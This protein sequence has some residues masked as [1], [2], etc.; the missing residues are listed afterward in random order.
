MQ[1][2]S[3]AAGDDSGSLAAAPLQP[4]QPQQPQQPQRDALRGASR[5]RQAAA[6]APPACQVAGCDA[7]LDVGSRYQLRTHLCALHLCA[8]EVPAPGGGLQRFCQGHHKMHPLAQF[9]GSTHTC[10]A[11]LAKMR[12]RKALRASRTVQPPA[13]PQVGCSGPATA[14]PPEMAL[15]GRHKFD[16]VVAV[17]VVIP[18]HK[19]GNPLAGFFFAAERPVWIVRP[20]FNSAE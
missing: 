20:V 3:A 11:K 5:G 8:L 19:R 16:A 14:A 4:L 2:A 1:S 17:L 18:I 7:R 12:E 6:S 15:L 9:T 13:A 10:T